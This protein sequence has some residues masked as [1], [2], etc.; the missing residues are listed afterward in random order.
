MHGVPASRQQHQKAKFWGSE[1]VKRM[2]WSFEAGAVRT[3]M[4]VQLAGPAMH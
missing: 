4:E 3:A 1:H 2:L